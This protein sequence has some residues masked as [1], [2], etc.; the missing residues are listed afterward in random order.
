ME[1]PRTA[2][3]RQAAEDFERFLK[4]CLNVSLKEVVGRGDLVFRLGGQGGKEAFSVRVTSG[5]CEVEAPDERGLLHATHYLE[6]LMVDHGGAFLP[7]G[8]HTHAPALSPRFTEGIFIPGMQSPLNPGDFSDEYLG[9]MSHFGANALKIYVDLFHLWQSEI[10]PEINS[11]EF[12]K[13]VHALRG[14]AQRLAAFGMDLFLHLNAGPLAA[15]H[16]V[17]AIHPEIRGCRA[18]IALEELSGRDWYTLCSSDPK[19]L[20]AYQEVLGAIFSA[21]PELAGAVMIIGGECFFHC[22][23]RP[24]H[25]AAGET[26]CPRCKGLDAHRAVAE[27]VNAIHASLPLGK[28]LLAWPYSAFTWSADDPTQ[29]RWIHHLDPG[30]EVMSNFDCF[31]EDV[32]CGAGARYFDYN[33]KLIGPSTVFRAQ[34]DACLERGLKIHAKTET[35]TT[36]DAF[37]LP[38]IPL[39]FRWYE[40]FR[41]IRESG[42]A[43]FMGQWRFYGMN[44]SIPEELQYHSVWNPERT[45]EELLSTIA[46]RDFGLNEANALEAVEAWR[47]MSASWDDF[48]YSAMTS[49]EREGYMR[50]PWYLGPAHPLIFSPQNRYD[51]GEKFF[52]LRGD[53]AELTTEEERAAMSGKPR[54]IDDLWICLPFGVEK[55]LNFTRACLEKWDAGLACLKAAL[56]PA[57]NE[58]ARM[59]QDVCETVSIHLHSLANCVEFLRLRDTI[60]R[61]PLSQNAL[62]E[63]CEKLTLVAE[64]EIVNASRAL[65]ILERDFRIGFGFAYGEVYDRE[66]ILE[67]LRQCRWVRDFEIPRVRSFIRFHLWQVGDSLP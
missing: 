13:Q 22:F 18:E 42:A 36:P 37:F 48:P 65:S 12:L 61:E 44:G 16:L 28:N 33:I 50:G 59:E 57:C 7:F 26:N 3:I 43:G 34:R 51:L 14:H 52:R 58:R 67:K 39:H 4:E 30:V 21:V 15:D 40:R 31:D 45:A 1:A 10:L 62:D 60:A 20:A 53:L 11:P 38:Y 35:T 9:L 54:Y 49:G 56:G 23:T 55:Y 8:N 64:R 24:A 19:V 25:A 63:I 47:M 29:S 27:F 17:F 66:M 46:I 5:G 41:A 2:L 32:R 6:R